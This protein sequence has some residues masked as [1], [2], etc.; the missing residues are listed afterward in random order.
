MSGGIA[1]VL[2]AAGESRRMGSTNKLAL[3]VGGQPLLRRTAG[4]LLGSRL[5]EIVVVLGHEASWARRTLDD[6]PVRTI[7][8]DNFRQGQM[9]SVHTGLSALER[10]VDGV[11]IC[12]AD[13]PLLV[14]ADI[15]RLI[16][17]YLADPG[18]SVLVPVWR[19]RRGNPIVLNYAHRDAIL[20]GDP[21]LGCRRFIERYP[22]L[23]TTIEVD[24]DSY[25][26]DLDTPEDRRRLLPYDEARQAVPNAMPVS[27]ED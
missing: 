2:L 20:D 18:C 25:V 17:A 22:D 1:A 26:T 6:L 24:S 5:T 27:A 19:G 10:A 15:D 4:T 14:S 7:Y 16:D 8:N 11:M 13:Q 21:K 9:T 12:L 3:S 23:V